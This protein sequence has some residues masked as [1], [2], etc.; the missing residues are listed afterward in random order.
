MSEL[1][2]YDT[3]YLDH[4]EIVFSKTGGGDLAFVPDVDAY[5]AENMPRWVSVSDRLPEAGVWY[6]ACS[7][8]YV[9]ILFFDGENEHGVHW[10]DRGDFKVLKVF[11]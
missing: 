2:Q 1:K 10:L 3:Y 4:G 11:M 6:L 9:R 8:K 7:A 5:I